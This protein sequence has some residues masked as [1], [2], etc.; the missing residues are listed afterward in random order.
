VAGEL[1]GR[2]HPGA[3]WPRP[4]T[5]RIRD[6]PASPPLTPSGPGQVRA[7]GRPGRAVKRSRP[8]I[9]PRGEHGKPAPRRSANVGA[10]RRRH[11]LRPHRRAGRIDRGDAGRG[12][13]YD[14]LRQLR[15]CRGVLPI[16][17]QWRRPPA[18]ASTVRTWG[19]G[20]PYICLA[21]S[22][23]RPAPAAGS[24]WPRDDTRTESSARQPAGPARSVWRSPDPGRAAGGPVGSQSRWD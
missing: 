18:Y 7:T 16:F 24:S 8:A 11:K 10:I 21:A 19:E 22:G 2:G 3:T 4:A 9:G 23:F 15:D 20:W 6:P 14:P 13:L 1:R 17:S 12:A 5:L